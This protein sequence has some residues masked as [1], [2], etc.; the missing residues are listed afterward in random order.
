MRDQFFNP[1]SIAVVGATPKKGK[2]GNTL[3]KNIL[4]FHR[5]AKG[6]VRIYAVNP[7]YDKI[8]NVL[9]YPSVLQIEEGVSLAVIA[10]PATSVPEV[11]EQCG[12]KGIKNV[13]VISAGFKEAGRE[14]AVLESELIRISAKYGLSLVGPNCVGLINTHSDLNATL[15]NTWLRTMKPK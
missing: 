15:S 9:C 8:L 3:L 1:E 12:L 13:V 2:V 5:K 4:S 10:V 7:K 6:S 14:G 11:L